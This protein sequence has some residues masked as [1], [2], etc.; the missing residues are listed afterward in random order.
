MSRVV[1]PLFIRRGRQFLNSAHITRI[2]LENKRVYVYLTERT[3]CSGGMLYFSGGEPLSLYW[4]FDSDVKAKNWAE[5]LV[6]EVH[7]HW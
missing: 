4:D 5:E 2:E 6:E 7:Y 1:R 3:G